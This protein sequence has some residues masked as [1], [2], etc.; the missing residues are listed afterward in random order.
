[1]PFRIGP[2][3]ERVQELE[4]ELSRMVALF[5]RLAVQKAILFGSLARGD[6]TRS[7]DID[8]I[9]VKETP[10]RFVDRIEEVLCELRP[11]VGLD[12]LVYTPQEFA[13]LSQTRPFVRQAVR[14]GRVLYE[15]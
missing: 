1:M 15:A 7:S 13:E 11:T 14:E 6:V 4:A 8:L 10:K 2:D 9:L 3:S 5:P 12:V